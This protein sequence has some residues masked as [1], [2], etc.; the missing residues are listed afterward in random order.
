MNSNFN[1]NNKLLLQSNFNKK[2]IEIEKCFIIIMKLILWMLKI[3]I[4][5]K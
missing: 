4:F 1:E 2:N 5:Q 3:L